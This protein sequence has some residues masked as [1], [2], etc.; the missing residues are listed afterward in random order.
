MPILGNKEIGLYNGILPK[1]C[2]LCRLGSKLVVFITGEC[3]D[4]CFYCP[5]SSERFGKDVIFANEAKIN[6][7]IEFIYEAYRMN[8]LGAGITGGDPILRL[9]RVTNLIKLL[10][11]E[12]GEGFHIHLYTTG[13]YVTHEVLRALERV[14]LDEIRFHPIK[15]EYLV[16]VEK[17]L[18]YSFDVGIEIPAIPGDEE[19]IIKLIEWA[20][21]KKV[22]FV[23]LNELEI[24]ERNIQNMII[25]GFKVAHG[26]TGAKGSAE[27]AEK[28]IKRFSEDKI[29]VHYCSSIYKDLVETRTRFL[30]TARYS[31]K[32][33]EEISGEGTIIRAFVKTNVDLS[34][35][36]ESRREGNGYYVSVKHI[37]DIIEK[38]REKID[39]IVLIEEHPDARRL[40]I[41]EELIYRK[42]E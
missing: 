8:A 10:K 33:Y 31:T 29:I 18:N 30:R 12:F 2:E 41:T 22:K 42:S 3:D 27:T 36:G 16:A 11:E 17:A 4:N 19:K 40:R 23:N 37:N 14:G 24:N 39:E 15:E 20:K 35:Y 32:P 1:G 26:L 5:V 38:Y 25:R 28:I 21:S 34:D 9:D 13:R 7:L 6:N